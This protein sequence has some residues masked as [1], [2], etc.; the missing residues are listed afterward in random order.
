MGEI[1]SRADY[2]GDE[3]M[4]PLDAL[5]ELDKEFPLIERMP[6]RCGGQP[7]LKDT[8]LRVSD[9]LHIIAQYADLSP[10][11]EQ[12]DNNYHIEQWQE[13]LRYAANYIEETVPLD[14]GKADMGA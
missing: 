7:T 9:V 10:A 13:A 8:R 1:K 5:V 11:L 3:P 14:R 6:G 12:W 4:S 2:A